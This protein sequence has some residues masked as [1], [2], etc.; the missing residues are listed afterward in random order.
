MRGAVLIGAGGP[1]GDERR[2]EVYEVVGDF[3]VCGDPGRPGGSAGGL[4]DPTGR[5]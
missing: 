4:P 5:A 3:D 2:I 1:D